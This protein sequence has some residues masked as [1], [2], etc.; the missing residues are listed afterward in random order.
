V[1]WSEKAKYMVII[2]ILI[3]VGNSF[4]S[5]SFNQNA[6]GNA[7][8]S[9]QLYSGI[10][11]LFFGLTV[12][13]LIFYGFKLRENKKNLLSVF[14]EGS[15]FGAIIATINL[16]WAMTKGVTIIWVLGILGILIPMIAIA[17]VGVVGAF[18]FDIL[19]KK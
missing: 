19:K 8:G 10:A 11:M 5:E 12:L 14:I 3:V 2:F 9:A 18:I 1:D 15:I 4:N 7:S 16:L 6:Y 13:S 17:V